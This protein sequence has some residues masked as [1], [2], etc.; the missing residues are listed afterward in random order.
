MSLLFV[1][2]SHGKL[3]EVRRIVGTPVEM[4]DI[5]LV[6]PQAVDLDVVV[7]AKAQQAYEHVRRPVIVEDSGLFISAWNGLPGALVK[8]F[9]QCVDVTGI[10]DMLH[11]FPVREATARTCV[12][13]HDGQLR[14]FEGT[15]KGSIARSPRGERGFGFDSIFIPEGSERTFG[16][17]GPEQKDQVSMRQRALTL[18]VAD[19]YVQRRIG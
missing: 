16:E 18:L 9:L 19:E 8:W 15:V 5:E 7:A 3:A 1:T 6:E 17:M 14:I 10:C 13:F 4:I 12:G 2:S 11:E